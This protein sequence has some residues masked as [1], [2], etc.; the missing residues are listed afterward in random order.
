MNYLEYLDNIYK[1]LYKKSY[2]KNK[3]EC[4]ENYLSKLEQV[5]QKYLREFLNGNKNKYN[6][7]KYLYIN[8]YII[9]EIDIP[10]SYF[11]HQ[12][13]IALERGHGHIILTKYEKRQMIDEIINDQKSSLNEWIDYLIGS[14][15][16]P[17]WFKYFVFQGVIKLGS[18]DKDRKCFFKR[19]KHTI[20]KFPDLNREALSILY[21]EM[22]KF[23]DGKKVRDDVLEALIKNGSFSKLYSHLILKLEKDKNSKNTDGIWRK[24]EQGSDAK[25]LVDTIKD[26]STGWCT[27][28]IETAKIQLELGDFYVYY[29]KDENEKY[30]I[31]RLAIRMEGYSIAEVRGVDIDQNI[32]PCMN[33]II[34]KKL[35]EFK[36]KETYKKKVNDMKLLTTIYNEYKNRELTIDELKFL[37]E[38]DS[39]IEGFGYSK[40]PRIEEI[41]ESRNIKLDCSK[42]F[43]CNL[44]E[45]A[46]SLEDLK[47]YDCTIYVGDLNISSQREIFYEE[48]SNLKRIMGNATFINLWEASCLSNLEYVK[49]TLNLYSLKDSKGLEKLKY[50]GEDGL[51][52]QMKNSLGFKSLNYVGGNLIFNKLD[53]AMGLENLKYVGGSLDFKNLRNSCGLD[54]L[55]YIGGE[56]IFNSLIGVYHLNNLKYIG[57]NAYFNH[58]PSSKGLENLSFIGGSANFKTLCIFSGLCN[59]EEI[60]GSLHI[61]NKEDIKE[62]KKL[63]SYKEEDKK[64]FNLNNYN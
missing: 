43:N 22:L 64:L 19:T 57:S 24:F 52:Y 13:K 11:D 34:D 18:L 46:I 40:D 56:A 26:K 29:T 6:Y 45:I 3:Y 50:I 27:A 47:N 37:Y 5:E 58:L 36:D 23:F 60:G 38:V 55:E 1:D 48:L 63:K 51:F 33:D 2:G 21:D 7:L 32:E 8:K 30:S 61:R 44:D 17:E 14:E 16:Y 15:V 4:I 9:K 53:E 59:L 39:N 62:L 28:G 10:E 25:I 42:I 35:D 41:K 20:T 31:P 49:G 12:C 54:T